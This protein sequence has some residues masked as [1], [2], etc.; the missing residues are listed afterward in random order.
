MISLHN[1]NTGKDSRE[2]N[3]ENVR[4]ARGIMTMQ[5]HLMEKN[6]TRLIPFC[7]QISM[8]ETRFSVAER[9]F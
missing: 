5:L 9:V 7:W 1:P 3:H 2:K 4:A 8:V 6:L